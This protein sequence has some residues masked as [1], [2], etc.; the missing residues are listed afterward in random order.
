MKLTQ[1]S[2]RVYFCQ[3]EVEP[4]HVREN[5]SF[6][7]SSQGVVVI[8]T[9]RTL[10]DARWVHYQLR[11]ATAQPVRYAINTHAHADHVF[12]NQLFAAPVVAHE[13]CRQ[14]MKDLLATEWSKESLAKQAREQP[15]PEA[16]QG[17][18]IVLPEITFSQRL[19]LELGDVSLQLLH[20]GGHVPELSVVYLPEEEILFISDL[21]F[22]GRYPAVIA[23]FSHIQTWIADLEQVE[24]M[25][26]R[27]VV[28]GHGP[29]SSLEQVSH[30]RRYLQ[31]MQ[32]RV[33]QLAAKGLSK[34]QIMADPSFPKYAERASAR[35]H[36]STIGVI[37]DE[38]FPSHR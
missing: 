34:E 6:V 14:R 29:L 1:V 3:G 16:L 2:P 22:V 17:L 38:L 32:Q 24:K 5:A 25:K 9:T 27:T 21:L 20:L 23:G 36:R 10:T 15:D 31:E 19:N 33:S 4:D 12:G 35:F 8:D 13:V 28:P 30:L 11:A 7:L 26:V 37:Y 18:R